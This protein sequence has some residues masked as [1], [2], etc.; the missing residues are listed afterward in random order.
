MGL[1]VKSKTVGDIVLITA[2]NDLTIKTQTD[3]DLIVTSTNRIGEPTSAVLLEDGFFL[4]LE[5]GFF[6][7]LE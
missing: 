2:S 1:I 6:L 7:L 3:G 4:L 5:D